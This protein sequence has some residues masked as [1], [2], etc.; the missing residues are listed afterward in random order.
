MMN[1][2]T[3]QVPIYNRRFPTSVD[4]EDIT[5]PVC[6]VNEERRAV[7]A[8]LREIEGKAKQGMSGYEDVPGESSDDA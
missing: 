2:K 3:I 5:V 4:Y 6:T 8:K 1:T 7:L